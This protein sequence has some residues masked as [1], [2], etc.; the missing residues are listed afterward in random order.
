MGHLKGFMNM[1]H[2]IIVA[3]ALSLVLVPSQS[4]AIPQAAT[5][6]S[7]VD[8]GKI[9][10]QLPETKQAEESLQA[11]ATPLQKELNRMNAAYQQS[12]VAYQQKAPSFTKTVREQKEKELK[13]KAQ[14]LEK[15]QQDNFGRGGTIEAKQ[16]ELFLPIRKKVLA[17]VESIATQEEV[18]L[19]LEKNSAIYVTTEND[20][21][22]KVLDK[23]NIK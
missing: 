10:Q 9:L 13:L 8:S 19:V 18:T 14:T 23:L 2:R 15:F 1:S 12:V 11:I 6:V 4:F 5:K 17:A 20:L 22:F 16:Q 21:T 3:A 7:V